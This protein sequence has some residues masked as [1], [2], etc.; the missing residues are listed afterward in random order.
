MTGG[1][2]GA[3]NSPPLCGYHPRWR[4]TGSLSRCP[5]GRFPPAG[6]NRR[7]LC[8]RASTASF[9]RYSRKPFT[10][11]MVVWVGAQHIALR[12]GEFVIRLG[13][14]SLPAVLD[15]FS[16]SILWQVDLLVPIEA[17]R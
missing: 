10:R 14:V 8:T 2:M 9:G 6:V 7:C 16:I 13:G 12:A 3:V 5:F 17:G 4:V 1:W 15:A 11:F